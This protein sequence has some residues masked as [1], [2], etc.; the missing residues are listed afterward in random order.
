MS[1]RNYLIFFTVVF[2]MVTLFVSAE[3]MAGPCY[4]DDPATPEDESLICYQ[5]TLGYTIEL[6]DAGVMDGGWERWQYLITKTK[7]SAPN[8]MLY[9]LECALTVSQS[10][11][12]ESQANGCGVGDSTTGVGTGDTLR[13]W[14]RWT[15]N[16]PRG[17]TGVLIIYVRPTGKSSSQPL[18]VKGNSSQEW[19]YILGPASSTAEAIERT[20]L[21]ITAEDGTMLRLTTDREGNCLE[22]EVSSDGGTYWSEISCDG[23]L[24][25]DTYYCIPP[26]IGYPANSTLFEGT[27]D[28][29][30]AHCGSVEYMSSD[31]TGQVSE[32]YRF[33]IIGG[34]VIYF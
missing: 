27:E 14:W 22:A 3:V 18:T 19:G 30:E 20:Q 33:I 4:Q 12:N 25:S 23:V 6:V 32:Q 7:K 13:Q 9:G 29:V 16:F 24:L 11:S 34:K 21:V 28:E 5:F 2:A 17:G 1:K 15:F 8:H 31:T 26:A 10:L